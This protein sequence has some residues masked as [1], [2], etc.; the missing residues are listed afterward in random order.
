MVSSVWGEA[1]V[2]TLVI[3]QDHRR[4]QLLY[5]VDTIDNVGFQFSTQNNLLITLEL[6]DSS[7]ATVLRYYY[8]AEDHR[9]TWRFAGK[10]LNTIYSTD[11]VIFE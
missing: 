9:H 5:Y 3:I 11:L 4:F 2:R 6:Q 1:E 7:I 10:S 8:A